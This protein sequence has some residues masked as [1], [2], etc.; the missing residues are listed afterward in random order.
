MIV[1]AYT[2][3][4]VDDY[5]RIR[6]LYRMALRD[7]PRL[8][9]VDEAADGQEA[10]QK[11]RDLQP[12]LVVLDL[13]M[14]RMDGLE[15]LQGIKR[16]SPGSRVVVLSGFMRERVAQVVHD[17]GANA[18]VE[19]GLA[20]RALAQTLLPVAAQAPLAPQPVTKNDLEQRVAELV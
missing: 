10:V 4:L 3:L 16:V 17:L 2:V 20:A 14:P 9:V 19:K 12:D 13:S 18:Y 11:A 1:P 6:Q 15:A 7:E 8:R 5:A